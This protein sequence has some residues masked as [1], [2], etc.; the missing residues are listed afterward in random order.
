[1]V[2]VTQVLINTVRT[3]NDA[4]FQTRVLVLITLITIIFYAVVV[5]WMGSKVVWIRI[6]SQHNV[7]IE[8]GSRL[9]SGSRKSKQSKILG[10]KKVLIF[11]FDY[12]IDRLPIYHRWP[13]IHTMC[14]NN[15]WRRVL[16][17]IKQKLVFKRHSICFRAKVS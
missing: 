8:I 2:I 13:S 17:F 6:C 12:C 10:L 4:V 1:M 16:I 5:F 7:K 9:N 3:V 15:F 11:L 14:W